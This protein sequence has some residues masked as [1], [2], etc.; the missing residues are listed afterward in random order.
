ME[1]DLSEDCIAAAI[2]SEG[3]EARASPDELL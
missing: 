1:V 3:H 2:A